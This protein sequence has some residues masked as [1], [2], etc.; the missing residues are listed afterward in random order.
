MKR[1][2]AL[3]VLLNV[4]ILPI[5]SAQPGVIKT[6]PR[7]PSREVLD[8]LG[9]TLAWQTRINLTGKPDSFRSVQLLPAGADLASPRPGGPGC[10]CQ[11]TEPLRA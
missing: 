10:G 3:A 4:T 5:A 11:Y 6:H 8:R 1:L 2:A 9:L 7:A